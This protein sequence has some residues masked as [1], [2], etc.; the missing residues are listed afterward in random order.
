MPF[1]APSPPKPATISL[2]A[3]AHDAARSD[4]PRRTTAKKTA[5]LVRDALETLIPGQIGRYSDEFEVRAF[6]DNLGRWGTA[7]VLIESGPLASADPD[8]DLVRLNFVAIVTA[9]DALASG[10]TAAHPTTAYDTLPLNE[11]SLLAT[12]I[13]NVSIVAGTGVPAF[14]GDVGVNVSRALAREP[15]PRRLIYAARIA[16]VGDLRVYGALE[17]IDGAGLTLTPAFDER[18]APGDVLRLPDWASWQGP[19]ISPG[20][21]GSL[22]LLE[23]VPTSSSN[24]A[25]TATL[26]ESWRLV[27]RVEPARSKS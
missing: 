20:Q 19:T 6:G 8:R 13:R 26:S 11:S 24:S 17:D 1:S 25:T 14:V 27:R 21:P 7:V 12:R 18:A 10:R 23:R 3:V 16:D 5:A 4:S 9:L 22:F 15:G 2:L